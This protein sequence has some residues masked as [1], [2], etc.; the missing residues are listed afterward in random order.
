MKEKYNTFVL[1]I[2]A[3]ILIGVGVII[4]TTL[5]IPIIGPLLFSFGLLSIIT[6]KLP[7]YTGRIGYIGKQKHLGTIL[8][9]N[10]IGVAGLVGAY[11]MAQPNFETILT[12]EKAATKFSKT[13]FELF[14]LGCIC[15]VL[16]HFAVR[17]KGSVHTMMA[18]MI[19]ILI[20]AEH[21]VA[22]FPF[23]LANL[24]W[25]NVFKFLMIVLG[26]SIG[27]IAIELMLNV[28]EDSVC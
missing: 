19:F 6:L 5:T 24:T 12:L 16:I 23:L 15:G 17:I 27:A 18:I 26:N 14:L 11:T 13:P 7:L 3:G 10:F 2:L 22:D 25:L 9:G 28:R 20:G 4:N 1:S 21:C 8:V